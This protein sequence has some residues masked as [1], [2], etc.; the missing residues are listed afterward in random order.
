M[1]TIS[2]G[3]TIRNARFFPQCICYRSNSFSPTLYSFLLLFRENNKKRFAGSNLHSLLHWELEF[4]KFYSILIRFSFYFLMRFLRNLNS[5]SRFGSLNSIN[6]D[7][8]VF[9]FFFVFLFHSFFLLF[10]TSSLSVS[11]AEKINFIFHFTLNYSNIA[12][13]YSL[14]VFI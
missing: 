12:Y 3:K 6:V 7:N 1:N 2:R 11:I 13:A 9:F 4:S 10:P 14:C 8:D 5:K